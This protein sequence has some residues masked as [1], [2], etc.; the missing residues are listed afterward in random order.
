MTNAGF[1]YVAAPTVGFG[2][3]TGTILGGTF[4]TAATTPTASVA[5][6]NL[7][8]SN[9]TPSTSVVAN[10]DDAAIPTNR[11]INILT[12]ASFSAGL[13]L[14]SGLTLFGSAPLSMTAGANGAIINLGGN[15]LFCSWSAYAGASSTFGATNAYIKNGSMSLTAKGG[16]ATLNFPFAGTFTWASGTTPT[17]AST[18]SNF[19]K[20]TVSDT[21]AP[22]NATA[23]SGIA[24]GSRAFR[25]Q[26]ADI[27]TTGFTSTP[28]TGLNP[29]ATLNFNSL[30]GLTVTQDQLF[31]AEATTLSGPWTT[32]STA[33][34]A[35]GALPTTGSKVTASVAPGPIVP[36]AD[37]YY[38]WSG[39]TPTITDINQLIV[40]ANSG[41]FTITGTNLTGV[42]AVKIGGTDVTSFT[43]VS[44][45]Q[46][47]G[48]AGN[49]TDGFV[50]VTKNGATI[51]GS[52]SVSVPSSPAGPSVSPTSA[53]INLGGTVT[54]TA[55]GNG[56]TFKWYNAATNGTLLF[57]GA[58]FNQPTCQNLW[59]A[60]Y[61][62]SCEGARTMIPVTIQATAIASTTTNFCGTGGTTALNAT[63]IDSNITYTWTAL[64]ATASLDAA[65]GATVNATVSETSDFQV[66]ATTPAGCTATAALSVG[67]YPLP[68]ATVTTTASGVCPGTSATINSGLSAGNFSVACITAPAAPATPPANAATLM[69]NNAVNPTLPSGVTVTGGT[70]TD[71]GYFSNVPI[72]FTFN[73]FGSNATTVFIGTN[74]TIN[75]GT[76]GNVGTTQYNFSGPPSGF[77]STANPAST[78]AVCAR[79]LRWEQGNGTIKYWT[80]GVAPNR[81]F[82]VQFLN[83]KPYAFT[84]GNQSAEAVLYETLGNVDIRV[85]EATNGTGTTAG[86]STSKYIGLQ[87][88][89][90]TVGATATNCSTNAANYWN[91]Q[92]AAIASTGPQAWRFAPPS[93]YTT[94]WQANG[95]NIPGEVAQTNHFSLSVAPVT[96]TTYSISYTNALT[97]CTNAAGS[98]QVVMSV[99]SNTAPTTAALANGVATPTSICNGASVNLSLDYTGLPDGLSFQWQS[100]TDGLAWNDI[101]LATLATT[102]VTPTAA[103]QYRCNVTS[104][105]GSALPSTPVAVSFTNTIATTTPA[106]RCGTGTISLD[107]TT[108]SVGAT[109]NWY[110]TASGGTALFT[111]SPY[112]PTLSATTTYYVAA[113]TTG[114]SSPRVAVTATVDTPPAI[115]LSSNAATYCSGS[116][117]SAIT[118]TGTNSYNTLTWS[119]ATFVSGDAIGGYIFNPT[120]STVYTLTASQ[121][122]GQLCATTA[123]FTVTVNTTN[124]IA[125]ASSNLLCALAPVDL[126]AVSLSLSTGPA[127]LPATP[128]CVA[129]SSGGGGS[130]PISSVDFNTIHNTDA[131]V[132]PYSISYPATGANTTTVTA[133]QT[134][135]LTVS[136][137]TASVAS[138]WID[139]DRSGTYDAS[140]WT[141]L[142]TSATTGTVNITIPANAIGG[143][144]GMRIRTRGTGNTNGSGDAC[145]AFFSGTSEDFTINLIGIADVTSTYN[146]S[147]SDGTSTVGST[148]G[149]TVNPTATTTYTV[150][151]TNPATTCS[152]TAT[153][154][155]VVNN[156]NAITNGNTSICTPSTLQL[157]ETSTGG[158]WSSSDDLIATVNTSG[159]VTSH[160]EGTATISYSKAT[161]GCPSPATATTS[162]TVNG[163]VVI[164]NSTSGQTSITGGSAIFAV[165]ASGTGLNYQWTYS[166]DGIVAYTNVSNDTNY[167]GATTNQLNITN[168]PIG[169]DGYKYICNIT[170]TSPCGNLSTTAAT[171]NVSGTGIA[172]QP[173]DQT[174]CSTGNGIAS[175]HVVGSSVSGTPSFTY[176][177]QVNQGSGFNTISATNSAITISGV[178]YTNARTS[179][180]NLS[181]V[182]VANNTWTYRCLVTESGL[183]ATSNGALLTVNTG[184]VAG[185]LASKTVCSTGGSTNFV[186]S[187]TGT[188]TG[189]TWQYSTDGSSWGGL[190]NGTPVGA[191]YTGTTTNTLTV[192]TT[193][194]TPSAGSYFYRVLFAGG[195]SCPSV[196]TNGAHLTINDPT[197]TVAPMATTVA[198]GSSTS[199]AVTTSAPS[200]TYQWQTA[201]SV[202]GTYSNVVNSTPAGITYTGATSATLNVVVA[203]SNTASATNFYRVVITSGGC[204]VTSTGVLLTVATY[205]TSA[206]TSTGDEDITN[207]TFG[208]LNNTSSCA[209]LVGTQGTATGTADLY[210]DFRNSIAAPTVQAGTSVPISVVITECAG[211]AYTHNV[212]VYFDFNHNGSL[213][214]AGEEFIIFASASS[215]THTINSNI[216]IP[217]TALAGNTI[218]R[219]VCQ[220]S[221]SGP[222]SVA[223]FGETEDYIVN[224]TLATP[225]SGTPV[226]GT[227]SP[228]ANFYC[229]TGTNAVNPF[230]A[231]G[232][233]TGSGI[234]FQWEQSANGTSGWTNATGG[235]G[236]TTASYTP[237]AS[238]MFYRMSITCSGTTTYSSVVSVTMVNCAFN[239]AV[240]TGTSFSSIMSTGNTYTFQN[241]SGDD[242]TS[243]TVSLSGTTFRYQDATVAG[244][245]ASTNGWLTFNTANTSTSLTNNLAS[246][247]PNKMLAPFWDDLVVTGGNFATI[248]NSM[249]YKVAGTLGSGTA[250]ITVEWA[251]MERFSV[252]GPNLNFQVKLYESDNHIEFVYGTMEGFDGT[253]ASNFSYSVGY[254]GTNPAGTTAIDRF[255]MQTARANHFSA[256]SDPGTLTI[257]PACN[258]TITFTPGTYSGLIAAPAITAPSN[259][260]AAGATVLPVNIAPLA[261][262]SFCGSYFTSNGATNSNV[263]PVC[264]T[265]TGTDDDDVWFK[266]TTTSVTD[267]SIVLRSAALYD[268]VLQLLDSSLNPISCMNNTGAGAIETIS[269]LGLTPSTTYFVRVYHNGTTIGTSNGQ[270]SLAV[271]SVL[272]PPT[273]DDIANATSL[274]VNTTCTTTSSQLPNTLVATASTTTPAPTTGTAD[275]DVWYSFVASS[276]L[277][278]ITVQSGSGYNAAMQVLSSSDNT[279][280]GTLTNLTTVNATSTG[281]VETYTGTF[282]QGNTYFV[283]VFHAVAGAGTGNFTICVTAPVPACTTN[284]TPA[285]NAIGQSVTPTLTWAAATYATAYDVYFGTASGA[286]TLLSADVATTSYTLTVG[287]TLAES[288]HY[289][290]YVVPKNVNGNATCG[291]INETSFTT[292]NVPP[293]IT[294]FTPSS[295]CSSSGTTVVITGTRF[296]N[297]TAVKLGTI[298]ATSYTVDSATQISAVFPSNATTGTIKVTNSYGTGT[299]TSLTVTQAVIYYADNDSDG[300]GNPAI[301]VSNCT[302]APLGYVISN[303]DCND[304]NA[305]I[306]PGALEVCGDGIDNDCNGLIDEVCTSQLRATS[307]GVTLAALNTDVVA[308]YVPQAQMYRFEVKN[309]STVV[310]TYDVN[311]YTFDLPKIAGIAYNTTYSV[312]VAVKIAGTWSFYGASC[313]VTTPVLSTATVLT[314]KIANSFCGTTLAALNT[315]IPAIAVLDATGYRFEITTGGVTTV[316]DSPTYNFT[317]AQAGVSVAYGTTYAIRV[318]VKVSGIYG[319]YGTS[320]N[321]STPVLVANVIPTTTIQTSFCGATLATLSTTIG[322]IPVFAATGYR[323]EITT[324]G[325]TTVYDSPTYYFMLSQA[326]VTV[327]YG[328][329]YSIR[330]AAQVGGIYGNYGASCSVTTQTVSVG[331]IPTTTVQDSFCDATLATLSTTI[332]AIPVFGASGYRFQIIKGSV[333][334]VYDSTTYNFMLSQTGTAVAYGSSYAIRVAVKIGSIY[335]NYGSTCYVSTPTLSTGTVP[336]TT[337][338]PSFCGA[339]LVALNTKIGAVPVYLATMARYEVTIAGGTPVV[340]E[341]AASNFMLSQTGVLVAYNTTY[342][343]RVA[344]EVGGVWGNYGA[345]CDVTTPAAPAPARLKAKSFDVTAYPNPYETEFV[346]SLESPSKED[347]NIYIYDM[348]GKLVETRQVN[349]LEVANLHIGG[350]FAAGIYNVIVSQ[351]N[352]MKS[353]RL[354]KK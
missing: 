51:T 354:I 322:A 270:F 244:F 110:A 46:I 52:Q 14:S 153:T 88:A 195:T 208:T 169:F 115:S 6:Y 308:D 289:F 206:A 76:T 265:T 301:S 160:A 189:R 5:L 228:S 23:G 156:V 163:Q 231:S 255:A 198:A 262:G 90:K 142:W 282:V 96:T 291:I 336:T 224:L 249:R 257:E 236:A 190:S 204:T 132:A 207:V 125:S 128:Y 238:A 106:T 273:N 220:A 234:S 53:S 178:T 92:L 181:G 154:T 79:D 225:C 72:G 85:F 165:S 246:G 69:L 33:F 274:T 7:T 253:V 285:N 310:G 31:V 223:S 175:F 114:C 272:L 192:T 143:Y 271:N 353:I 62:G 139:Y 307:C 22:T 194:A 337:I 124:V 323:F 294:S 25:V 138:V 91:G 325:N 287:Q 136:S 11:K 30:D 170:G 83:G 340:Y 123:T 233:S 167:S 35:S 306:H 40:C 82:V 193:N 211:T 215:S 73:Y 103:S 243:T 218:M 347:V 174:L 127:S 230:V 283:R 86:T 304:S 311:R 339:T 351:A 239:T 173:A 267:Y 57:T 26:L 21:A 201:T 254:N 302:G 295:V 75:V 259:D 164:N 42:S 4:A 67:V 300:Y 252:A 54:V 316:Y 149:L 258:S 135:A 319:N 32:R 210:S 280:T 113:E 95:V 161:V 199:F 341:V 248:S 219:V 241:T 186:A 338:Q 335:G 168:I 264:A 133:G 240:N 111:G 100:S 227:I 183:T 312:R 276:T 117:S 278:T 140:E 260:D 203:G 176:S 17:V 166:P 350:N 305:S 16:S 48:V 185:T 60:E 212:R 105:T 242:N 44:A 245:Q 184:V 19:T 15:N 250:V 327:A 145:T 268:G 330:V 146:Y 237:V 80:E 108:D 45:T 158:T 150:T 216:S 71:D 284:S 157:S 118:A 129:D 122:G 97:G 49:G 288:T 281:G 196:P 27:G 68:S 70:P 107:A 47:T 171:L 349:Y 266:F 202:G 293:A 77:P 221:G 29:T 297:V 286:E 34:G 93:N 141:Q 303:T 331:S 102:T 59:V 109:I 134:Y 309:G 172:T 12:L 55:S 151:A 112:T 24:I 279:A 292:I 343:I 344:A 317:L 130:S 3:T 226:A 256:T 213:T 148:A 320:C 321:V 41:T 326:G 65:T 64:T 18:G 37:S 61:N 251:G 162:V 116:A 104:C 277:N 318:A 314:T 205:C 147:W 39:T 182:T 324:G 38:A 261:S 229:S 332:G 235:T 120:A 66:V 232:Y 152:N 180:L 275:D 131:Q 1:G 177:W 263:G 334:S 50:S 222:C 137:G 43:V 217:S 214:D 87:D 345:S 348:V 2:P 179:T 269:A 99:L 13:N 9:F 20:V 187:A 119:P 56:G 298:A 84:T 209:S 126:S 333:T 315:K 8:L 98:A 299:S 121:T 28:V 329:T 74:G 290:W 197:I 10:G 155:V 159:L 191:T 342:S 144:T 36:T 200:A 81:R 101:A 328:T 94:T 78:I 352:E 188:I 296:V 58:T 346:L 89:T 63:P 313:N 247:T